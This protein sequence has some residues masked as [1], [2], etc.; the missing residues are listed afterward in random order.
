MDLSAIDLLVLDVDGVLTAGGVIDLEDSEMGRVFDIHDGCCIRLWNSR[1]GKTAVISGRRTIVVN[2]R[3]R[4]LGIEPVV[5]GAADKLAAYHRV[6]EEVHA[7]D[8]R[9]CY[10]GDDLPD[11]APMGRCA[12]PVATANAVCSVKQAA[13]YVTRSS[14]G[15][16]AVA[17]VIELIMRKQQRWSPVC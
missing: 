12:F 5:Q 1:G 2:R 7:G 8:E 16:G 3:A 10:V 11:L 15:R 17:E 9:V 4:L 14:G 6:L 13:Q